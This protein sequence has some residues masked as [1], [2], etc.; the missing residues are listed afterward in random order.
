MPAVMPQH[1]SDHCT[2]DAQPTAGALAAYCLAG[3]GASRD[4]TRDLL[5]PA[6]LPTQLRRAELAPLPQSPCPTDTD[7]L[8]NSRCV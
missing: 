7:A 4:G 1:G 3:V 2:S 8:Y 5:Y 6:S